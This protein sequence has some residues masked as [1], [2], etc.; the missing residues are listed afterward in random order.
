M[1]IQKMAEHYIFAALWADAPEGTRPRATKKARAVALEVCEKFA[2]S[3]VE[4]WPDILKCPAYWAHPDCAGHPEG[5]VGHDLWLT[6]AGHGVGFFDRDT[7]PDELLEKLTDLAGR[8]PEA[9][10]YRGWLYLHGGLK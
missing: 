9:E 10:F 8:A 2:G 6:S 1:N 5:A 3:I 4:L 7:L